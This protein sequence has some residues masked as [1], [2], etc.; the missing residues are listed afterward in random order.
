MSI[1]YSA[2]P[3]R[4]AYASLHSYLVS[5]SQLGPQWRQ[6]QTAWIGALSSDDRIC[7]A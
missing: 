5:T 1:F 4:L 6:C 3:I 2:L 7:N